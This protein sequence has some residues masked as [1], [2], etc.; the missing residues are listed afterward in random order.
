MDFAT[1]LNFENSDFVDKNL[2]INVKFQCIRF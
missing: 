1:M 2:N